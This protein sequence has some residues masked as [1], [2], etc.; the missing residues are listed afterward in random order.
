MAS[1]E[2]TDNDWLILCMFVSGVESGAETMTSRDFQVYLI[3]LQV[4][5]AV[6]EHVNSGHDLR[7][8]GYEL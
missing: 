7:I 1:N 4:L 6:L 2:S 5:C 8:M 3:D